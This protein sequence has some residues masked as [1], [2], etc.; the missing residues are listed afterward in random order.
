MDHTFRC[1]LALLLV[2]KVS[3]PIQKIFIKHFFAMHT[4]SINWIS[5]AKSDLEDS[6]R[7]FPSVIVGIT[8]I[9]AIVCM[10]KKSAEA[11][12]SPFHKDF[13]FF[14]VCYSPSWIVSFFCFVF[15]FFY[16]CLHRRSLEET[17]PRVWC[18]FLKRIIEFYCCSFIFQVLLSNSL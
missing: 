18:V 8:G 6:S 3:D 12:F 9:W 17:L 14:P 11:T 2:E 7:G 4:N 16:F 10:W 15:R 13:F 5:G 1:C